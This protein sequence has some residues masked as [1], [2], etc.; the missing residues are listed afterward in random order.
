[1]GRAAPIPA[2]AFAGLF[3]L[4]ACTQPPAVLRT[5]AERP[6]TAPYPTLAPIDS[7]LAAVPSTTEADPAATVGARAATLRARAAEL[8][9]VQPGA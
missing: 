4:A 9:A 3:L 2:A 8:R 7:L 6:G 1:M 5:G